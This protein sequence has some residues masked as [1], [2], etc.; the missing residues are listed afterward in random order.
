MRG[1]VPRVR[2]RALEKN[3]ARQSRAKLVLDN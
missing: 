1:Y 3:F 2:A